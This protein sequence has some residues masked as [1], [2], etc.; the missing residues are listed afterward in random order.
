MKQKPNPMEAIFRKPSEKNA[1]AIIEAERTETEAKTK[2]LREMRLAR[3]PRSD[4][5][6]TG[7]N[8]DA[9]KDGEK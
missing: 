8:P 9:V 6:G 4:L 3:E 5:L 7:R 1:K 2:R